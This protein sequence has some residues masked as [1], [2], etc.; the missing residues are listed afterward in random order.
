ML[1]L[2]SILKSLLRAQ[3]LL[4]LV[5][6]GGMAL[7]LSGC[8][9]DPLPISFEPG[10][11]IRNLDKGWVAGSS[12]FRN[13]SVLSYNLEATPPAQVTCTVTGPQFRTSFELYN[14]GG[15]GRWKDTLNFVDSLSGD[16]VGG[17][18]TY[19]RRINALFAPVPGDYLFEFHYSDSSNSLSTQMSVRVYFNFEPTITSFYSPDTFPSG[20]WDKWGQFIVEV[21]DANGQ[22]DLVE[23][24][25]HIEPGD[26]GHPRDVFT[27]DR[28]I[29]F[30]LFSGNRWIIA[31][32]ASFAAGIPTGTYRIFPTAAD[33]ALR[34][35]DSFIQGPYWFIGIENLPPHI[36]SVTGPDTV[37]V[38]AGDTVLFSYDV[39]VS[40]PQTAL[41]LDSLKMILSR[42]DPASERNIILARFLYLD[43]GHGIDRHSQDG[44]YTAGFSASDQSLFNTAFT[45]TWIA[46]DRADNVSDTAWTTVTL[47]HGQGIPRRDSRNPSLFTSCFER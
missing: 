36:D 17:D 37:Y 5:V 26:W 3:P 9:N 1:P 16:Q 24:N 46:Q 34:T 31:P 23:V 4:T 47:L 40:D 44:H 18:D 21:T 2:R 13:V 32:T 43:D 30:T 41:D 27:E 12:E 33:W 10:I 15:Y 42:F 35:R 20:K 11:R 22:T 25:L 29:R 38:P 19:S 28:I 39:K 8:H 7:L 14:D 45:M 6:E